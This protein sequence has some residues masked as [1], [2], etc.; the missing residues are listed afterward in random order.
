MDIAQHKPAL[1]YFL[2]VVAWI[3]FNTH[4]FADHKEHV[5]DLLKRVTTVSVGTMEVVRGMEK[6]EAA[7]GTNC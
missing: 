1:F 7:C 2:A 3:K 6:V 4:S 5:I